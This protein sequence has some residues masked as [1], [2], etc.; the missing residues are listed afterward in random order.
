M[1]P[2][3]NSVLLG[4]MAHSKH[5]QRRAGGLRDIGPL[6]QAVLDVSV[7]IGS[8]LVGLAATWITQPHVVENA[9]YRLARVARLFLA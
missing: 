4:R 3:T 6:E 9:F 7:P 8:A 2:G 5:S 1:L